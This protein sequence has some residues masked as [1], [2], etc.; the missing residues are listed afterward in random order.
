MPDLDEVVRDA[1]TTGEEDG[2]AI[3]GERVVASV[4]AFNVARETERVVG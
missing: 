3:A 2:S 4:R 1:G